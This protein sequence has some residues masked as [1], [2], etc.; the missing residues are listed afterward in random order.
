MSIKRAYGGRLAVELCALA[1]LSQVTS[2]QCSPN[3]RSRSGS[4]TASWS[5]S[6]E[7]SETLRRCVRR[8][9]PGREASLR[10]SRRRWSPTRRSSRADWKLQNTWSAAYM[11]STSSRSTKN[12]GRERFG[13]SPNAFTSAFKELDPIPQFKATAKLG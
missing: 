5:A 6:I 11:T 4:L 13:V 9:K 10:M 2:L 1:T 7:C 8:L 12:S 3:T